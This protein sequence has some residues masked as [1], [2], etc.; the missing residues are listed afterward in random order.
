MDRSEDQLIAAIKRVLSGDVPGVTIPVGDD[1]A[2]VDA[3]RHQA[4]LTADMLVEGVHF[5]LDTSSAHDLGYKAI[6]VNLSDLAAMGASPRYGL[7]SLAVP[8]DVEAPWVMEL[9][10]GI[11]EAS[12]EHGMSIVGGDLSGGDQVVISVSLMGTVAEKRAVA[13]SGARPGD[14]LAVTGVLGASAGG[15]RLSQAPPHDV[16]T[17]LASEWGRALVSAYLR[18]VPRIGEGETLAG[19]GATAMIDVSDGLAIDLSRLCADSK[20]GARLALDEVP[21][22]PGLADLAASLSVDPMSLALHGGEDYEL[23]VALP[24]EIVESVAEKLLDRFATPLSVVG[25]V[26]ESLDLVA[27]AADGTEAP[28][29]ARGWDHFG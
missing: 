19:A 8:K 13:R 12:E 27:V 15:L 7:V 10:G 16:R 28:L 11:R 21:V 17:A 20:V 14:V 5:Q 4:V 26:T 22:A 9:Y 1:A 2:V 23:L 18:P 3:G 6:A 25:E 29:E 24:P